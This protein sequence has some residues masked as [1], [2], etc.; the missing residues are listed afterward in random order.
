MFGPFCCDEPDFFVRA[1]RDKPPV[2]FGCLR[3]ALSD[4]EIFRE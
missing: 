3:M 2:Q 1:M 4:S